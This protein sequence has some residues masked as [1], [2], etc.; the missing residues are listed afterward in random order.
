MNA[1]DWTGQMTLLLAQYGNIPTLT[2]DAA[3]RDWANAVITL[4]ALSALGAARPEGFGQWD[5]WATEF[6]RTYALLET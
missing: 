4:P 2:N 1:R 6:N 3:W 5:A